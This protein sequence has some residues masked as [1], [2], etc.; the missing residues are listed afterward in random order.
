MTPEQELRADGSNGAIASCVAIEFGAD[1]GNAA[2][3][4]RQPRFSIFAIEA[5]HLPS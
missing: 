4:A 3:P 5:N 2:P 1:S